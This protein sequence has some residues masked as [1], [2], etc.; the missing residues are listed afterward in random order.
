MTKEEAILVYGECKV[1]STV[2]KQ[3]SKDY[4]NRLGLLK[5]A[6]TKSKSEFDMDLETMDLFEDELAQTM[7]ELEV[8]LQN[9]EI[10]VRAD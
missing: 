9:L 8:K 3:K 10:F 6:A 5:K 2:L 7:S 1:L 4:E